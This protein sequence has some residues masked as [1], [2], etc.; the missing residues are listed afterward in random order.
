MMEIAAGMTSFTAEEDVAMLR[1][2]PKSIK[3]GRELRPPE[4]VPT[5]AVDS[6]VA[7]GN[8]NIIPKPVATTSPT[9][10]EGTAFVTS[11]NNCTIEKHND[12]IPTAGTSA[13][14]ALAA[15]NTFACENNK[16]NPNPFKNP[17]RTSSETKSAVLARLNTPNNPCRIADKMMHNGMY[18]TPCVT[19]K[20]DNGT[21]TTAAV[22]E[23]T[24]ARLPISGAVIPMMTE[25]HR[26]TRGLT[27][28]MAEQAIALERR[29]KATVRPARAS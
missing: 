16:M 28:T 11:G 3:L 7:K 15:L 24:P 8:F 25:D 19:V 18:S 13:P 21:I 2:C 23:M 22:P 4:N 9:K 27:P 14:P 17:E 26:P 6:K 10:E 1:N 20:A 29:E 5:G 12:A